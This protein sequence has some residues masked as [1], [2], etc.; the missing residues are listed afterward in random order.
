MHPDED[1]YLEVTKLPVDEA[2]RRVMNGELRD[3]KT[4]ALVLRV[5]EL[6]RTGDFGR[7]I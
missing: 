6:L 2:V 4:Q 7:R 3:G 1:E 5:A